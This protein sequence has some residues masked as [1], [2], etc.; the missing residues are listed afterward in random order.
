MTF[1]F[2]IECGSNK[3]ENKELGL[4]GTCN[5]ARRDKENVRPKIIKQ[6]KK[7]SEKRANELKEYPSKK[8]KF[9]LENPNCQLKQDG[10]SGKATQIHHC[11]VL[12][13]NFLN[14][15]TWK[16]GCENCHHFIEVYMPAEERRRLGL[17]TD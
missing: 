1:I 6:V 8:R 4:C 5:K 2:C 3:I 10:C 9:L 12:A 11:S 7:V 17:L 16:G 14:E 13:K 15:K